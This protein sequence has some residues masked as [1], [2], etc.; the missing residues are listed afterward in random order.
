MSSSK[1]LLVAF[2][3][4]L[5]IAVIIGRPLASAQE[6]FIVLR[7]SFNMV[8]T[9][10]GGENYV[11]IDN[12]PYGYLEN[13]PINWTYRGT[14]AGKLGEELERRGNAFLE[15]RRILEEYL[16]KVEALLKLKYWASFPGLDEDP[17]AIY[18]GLYRPT[19]EQM[20]A[21]V[22]IL[23][24][25][26]SMKGFIVKFYEA[27]SYKGLRPE[28]EEAE[29][30]LIAEIKRGTVG[31]PIFSLSGYNLPGWLEIGIEYGRIAEHVDRDFVVGIVKVVRTVVGHKVPILFNFARKA[32]IVPDS[33]QEGPVETS[34]NRAYMIVPYVIVLTTIPVAAIMVLTL[35]RKRKIP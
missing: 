35:K 34:L 5:L 30:Q 19:R 6:D 16:P 15:L 27:Y 4:I 1:P 29:R 17:P 10:V 7:A 31:L 23:G 14:V 11:M 22:H 32:L 12:D 20:S 25:A 26:A 18:V 28:L 3:M 8:I 24:E 33:L 9:E 21:V 2:M 13:R